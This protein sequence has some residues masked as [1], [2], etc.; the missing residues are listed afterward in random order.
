MLPLD[1]AI[2]ELAG[3][4]HGTISRA[5]L[6][7]LGATRNAITHRVRTGRL[8]RLH[9]GVYRV[10]PT[11]TS[12]TSP[13]AAALACG[14]G[15]A[16]SHHAAAALHKI[17]PPQPGPIDVTVPPRSHR[18]NRRG[19]RVHRADVEI[20]RVHGIPTTTVA[21]A[22]LDIAPDVTER[23]LQRAVEEA[24]IQKKLHSLTSAIDQA[25]GHRRARALRATSEDVAM[26]RSEAERRLI[27][28]IRK[29][30]LPHPLTKVRIGKWEVDVYWPEQKLV[31]EVDGFAF[32]S[33]HAAFER[34]RVKA[35]ELA[36]A[37]LRLARVTW[38]QIARE[39]EAV[40][41]RLA[42]ALSARP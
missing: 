40:I 30:G 23:D 13:A 7:A 37:G 16:I 29:A 24:Q 22:L 9:H 32:H 39:P 19:I 35:T 41:A 33:T 2:A 4:Q 10:G 1:S 12:L 36:A 14:P 31:V 21:R 8:T 25:A 38:R 5:Q 20:V 34:D 18:R 28:L 26:T 15:A 42:G 6:E 11:H 3:R 27:E 17:R